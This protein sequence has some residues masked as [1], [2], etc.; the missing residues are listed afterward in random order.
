MSILLQSWALIFI[1]CLSC[2]LVLHARSLIPH[3]F[4]HTP[5]GLPSSHLTSHLISHLTILQPF[6]TCYCATVCSSHCSPIME[7]Q[8]TPFL[9]FSCYGLP[10]HDALSID[11][12]LMIELYLDCQLM[13]WPYY[14]WLYCSVTAIVCDIL[15]VYKHPYFWWLGLK[16]NLVFNPRVVASTQ[17]DSQSLSPIPCCFKVPLKLFPSYLITRTFRSCPYHLETYLL[18]A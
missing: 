5:L 18:S 17:S 3:S 9:L 11:R 6:I 15:L 2:L 7:C 12:Q 16:P 10:T 4:P 13:M 8:L 1:F 14:I